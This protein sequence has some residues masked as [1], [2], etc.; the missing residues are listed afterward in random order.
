MH[1]TRFSDHVGLRGRPTADPTRQEC[2]A[3]DRCPQRA[4][5]QQ[6]HYRTST[7]RLDPFQSTVPHQSWSCWPWGNESGHAR[8]R[9]QSRTSLNI[10]ITRLNAAP[11]SKA[12]RSTATPSGTSRIASRSA[13]YLLSS[14]GKSGFCSTIPLILGEPIRRKKFPRTLRN[15]IVSFLTWMSDQSLKDQKMNT[16]NNQTHTDVVSEVSSDCGHEIANRIHAVR[17][18]CLERVCCVPQRL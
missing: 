3:G 18:H 8:R 13:S 15:S 6:R 7:L 12:S 2:T 1:G 4:A 14:A 17:L 16:G 10:S 5:P 11:T 9:R